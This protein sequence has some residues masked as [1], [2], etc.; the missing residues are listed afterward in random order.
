MSRAAVRYAK[1][2]L[3]VAEKQN[4]QKEVFQD[5]Q[6][7]ATTLKQSKEL[8]LALKSPIIKAQ[9]KK[10]VLNNVFNDATQTTSD[11]FTLLIENK[12]GALVQNVA[13]QYSSLYNTSIG[14]VEAQVT[15]A[16]AIDS[17][18]EQKVLSKVQQ[19][20]N[21]KSISIKNSIDPTIIGGFV[22]KI[23]DT[24]YDASVANNFLKLK[25]EFSLTI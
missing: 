6:T 18:L 5:M 1:A 22:L 13:E 9:D 11:A 8:R 19:L 15:T 3:E 24:Q 23:G 7:I 10:E 12:R 17:V 2:I 14:A 21:A 4:L 16:I 20:T 25:K